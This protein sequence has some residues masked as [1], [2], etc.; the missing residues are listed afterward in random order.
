MPV[1]RSGRIVIEIDPEQKQALYAALDRDGSSLKQW[2]LE[3]V[4]E[5]L[6][7]G[8]QLSLR[9]MV[10]DGDEDDRGYG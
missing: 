4:D 9:L 7:D 1:G 2:F 3:R 5:Y 10:A 6:R 8:R